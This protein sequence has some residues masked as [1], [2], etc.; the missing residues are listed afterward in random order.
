MGGGRDIAISDFREFE[1]I[2][3]WWWEERC[4]FR[5]IGKISESGSRDARDHLGHGR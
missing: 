4:V 5:R 1:G 3:R 2:L